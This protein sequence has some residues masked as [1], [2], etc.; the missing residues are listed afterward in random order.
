MTE[1]Y[2]GDDRE[3]RTAFRAYDSVSEPVSSRT[4]WQIWRDACAWQAARATPADQEPFAWAYKCGDQVHLHTKKLD[5]YYS[6][7]FGETY[8]KGIPLYAAPQPPQNAADHIVDANKKVEAQSV[9]DAVIGSTWVAEVCQDAD[10]FK[11]IEAV[12]EDLDDFAAGTRLY[13]GG[14]IDEDRIA[15]LAHE[16]STE[17]LSVPGVNFYMAAEMAIELTLEM[18]GLKS[19]PPQKPE[20]IK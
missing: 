19:A 4:P 5:H 1:R 13:A 3:S 8:V 7:D 15:K 11:H 10:G 14:F 20:V 6:M 17:C 9:R 18:L 2:D 12:V 16:V